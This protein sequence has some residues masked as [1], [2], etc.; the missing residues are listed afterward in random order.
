MQKITGQEENQNELLRRAPYFSS[1]KYALFV[2][3][4]LNKV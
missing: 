1:R 3:W 4:Q 2:S